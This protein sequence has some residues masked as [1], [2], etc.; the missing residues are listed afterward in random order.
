M[1]SEESDSIP[2]W[3]I[4]PALETTSLKKFPWNPNRKQW[5][6]RIEKRDRFLTSQI[7]KIKEI[8]WSKVKPERAGFIIYQKIDGEYFFC[9]GVDFEH[10]EI[11]DFAGGISYHRDGTA[12]KGA[13]RELNEESLGIFGEINPKDLDDCWS[14]YN[15]KTMTIFLPKSFDESKREEYRRIVKA[16]DE[17]C[18][19]VLLSLDDFKTLLTGEKLKFDSGCRER[20]LYFRVQNLINSSLQIFDLL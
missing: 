13:L 19:L 15:D 11:T 6:L 9:L 2:E 16:D 1:D 4:K 17:I 20:A 10:G 18:D 12:L 8:D 7:Q 14:I 3:R 5:N